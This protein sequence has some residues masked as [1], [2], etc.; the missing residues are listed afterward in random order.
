MEMGTMLIYGMI[1]LGSALMIYNIVEYIRFSRYIR[2]RGNWEK[3]RNILNF[4]ILLLIMFLCGYLAIAFFGSPDIIVSG[5]LFGGSVFVAVILRLIRRIA[6]RIQENEQLESRLLASEKANEAKSFFL[7]NMSHDIRTPLNAI[8]GYTM[9]AQKEGQTREEEQQYLKKID[10]AGHQLLSLVNDVLEMSRID[11]GK[12]ELEPECINIEKNVRETAELMNEQMEAKGIK[13]KVYC[14]VEHPCV[15]CDGNHLDRVIMNLLGNACKFTPEGGEVVLSL[16]QTDS[17]PESG[18]F[19]IRVKDNGIGMS[20]EFAKSV[21]QPFERE[22][23]SSVSKTQGT[24]LGMAITKKIIDLMEGDIRLITEKGKGSEFIV[25]LNL[26]YASEQ[27][28]QTTCGCPMAENKTM[29][30]LLAE[31]NFVNREIATVILTDMG[32]EIETAEDGDI[33]V[34]ML[35][36]REPGYYQCILMDIQMPVMDGY[37]ATRTIRSLSDEQLSSIP[38]I[39]MTANAF[40]EDVEAS[41]EAGMQGHVAKPIDINALQKTLREVLCGETEPTHDG[42]QEKEDMIASL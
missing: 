23:T 14:D 5:I 33:A 42:T 28:V 29:R 20:E 27:Q 41:K 9:L 22:R 24:G 31:D 38:I 1:Y 11:S 25:T 4:P 6:N 12:M 10:V 39:A 8:L 37:E 2:K 19:E 16:K 21:F 7:S 17:D 3:E 36:S 26:P 30:L 15:L 35:V 18:H 32:F 34:K 40:K 13:Y